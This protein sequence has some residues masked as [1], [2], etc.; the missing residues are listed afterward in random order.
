V[1]EQNHIT[2]ANVSVLKQI[3][4]LIPQGLINRHALEKG[5]EAK[6]RE[7]FTGDAFGE[8]S[9]TDSKRDRPR[10]VKPHWYQRSHLT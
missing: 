8:S 4:N 2:R 3:L 1:N 10:S 7:G 9:A 5:V 6:T